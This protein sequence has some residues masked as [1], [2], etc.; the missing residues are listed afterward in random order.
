MSIFEF[1]RVWLNVQ[2]A[3]LSLLEQRKKRKKVY[4]VPGSED[5]KIMI[6]MR[7]IYV[8]NSI[9]MVYAE[10]KKEHGERMNLWIWTMWINRIYTSEKLCLHG[11]SH[12]IGRLFIITRYLETYV[13]NFNEITTKNAFEVEP[14]KFFLNK[15]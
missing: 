15:F 1:S 12:N 5:D 4:H 14:H 2:L 6:I 8:K 10:K 13:Q 7:K 3:P 9:M 11:M